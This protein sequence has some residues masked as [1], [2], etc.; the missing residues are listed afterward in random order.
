MTSYG[1]QREGG[2]SLVSNTP[3]RFLYDLR[4]HLPG[5]IMS[6]VQAERYP[7]VSVAHDF[8]NLIEYPLYTRVPIIGQCSADNR[9]MPIVV[10]LR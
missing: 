8:R 4:V 10:R 6:I 3:G 2:S 7:A 5:S 1:N 9:Y